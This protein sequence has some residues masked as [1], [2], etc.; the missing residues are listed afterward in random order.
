MEKQTTKE[1]TALLHVSMEMGAWET[2]Q[3]ILNILRSRVS[4]MQWGY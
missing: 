2:A 4:E 1:L 3:A